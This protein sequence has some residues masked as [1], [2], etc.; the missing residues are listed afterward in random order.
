[1]NN[2]HDLKT[3]EKSE[4]IAVYEFLTSLL[5]KLF[6]KYDDIIIDASVE[7][8]LNHATIYLYWKAIR[9]YFKVP[10]TTKRNKKLVRQTILAITNYLNKTYQFQQPIQFE[11]HRSDVYDREIGQKITTFWTEFKTT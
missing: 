6:G 8:E 7:T 3:S 9:Q 4:D 1:M 10:S 2:V 11:S 5:G